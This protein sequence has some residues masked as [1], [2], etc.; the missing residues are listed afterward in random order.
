RLF[1]LGVAREVHPKLATGVKT[2]AL[3]RKLD[4]CVE[5]LGLGKE[6]VPWRLRLMAVT[7]NMNHDELYMWLDKIR[8]KRSDSAVVRQGVVIGPHVAS[9]LERAGMTDW[10]IYKGLQKVS[11]EALVFALAGLESEQAQDHLRRYLTDIRHRTISITGDDL[12]AL[13]MK[14]DPAIGRVLEKIKEMRVDGLIQGRDA[15]LEQARQLVGS[16]R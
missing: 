14:R 8:L 6:V 1:E 16:T 15:E 10:E 12:H 4:S 11:I 5:E 2:V 3:V 9:Q 13:G 7:R